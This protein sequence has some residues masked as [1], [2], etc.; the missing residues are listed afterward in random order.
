[1]IEKHLPVLTHIAAVGHVTY[2]LVRRLHDETQDPGNEFPAFGRR[3]PDLHL[4]NGGWLC[5]GT[6]GEKIAVHRP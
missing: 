4:S 5:P 1:M 6:N 2:D 3:V